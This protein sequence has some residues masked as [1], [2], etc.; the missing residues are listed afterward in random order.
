MKNFKIAVIVSFLFLADYGAAQP[1]VLPI[2]KFGGTQ[3]SDIT[4]VVIISSFR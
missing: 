1:G 2:S 4:Q 3:N